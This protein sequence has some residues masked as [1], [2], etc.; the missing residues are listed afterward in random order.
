MT[1]KHT[2]LKLQTSSKTIFEQTYYWLLS[3]DGQPATQILKNTLTCRKEQFLNHLELNDLHFLLNKPF[4][5]SYEWE[6]FYKIQEVLQLFD[7]RIQEISRCDFEFA[8]I[9][10]RQEERLREKAKNLETKGVKNE[11]F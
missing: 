3:I 9:Q 5:S 2:T 10:D 6:L 4:K 8:N 7:L 11:I 1:D